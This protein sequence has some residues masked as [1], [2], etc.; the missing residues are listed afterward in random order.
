MSAL[1]P[2]VACAQNSARDVLPTT[3]R[4]GESCRLAEMPASLQGYQCG[5]AIP[6]GC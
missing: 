1:F 2:D 5:G 4:Q 6:A 3:W